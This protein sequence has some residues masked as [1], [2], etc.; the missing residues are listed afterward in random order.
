MIM[1]TTARTLLGRGA[2]QDCGD[3]AQATVQ[4]SVDA[5]EVIVN[6]PVARELT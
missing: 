4:V 5:V 3:S 6:E 2:C 1:P